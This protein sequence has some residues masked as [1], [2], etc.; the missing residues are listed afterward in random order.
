MTMQQIDTLATIYAQSL[1][2]L[3]EEAGGREK[4]LEL[5]EELEQVSE[6]LAGEA[7]LRTLF[8]TPVIDEETRGGLIRRIFENR[9]TDLL[10]RF[11]LV[12]NANDRLGHFDCIQASYDQMVQDTFGRVEVDVV[13]AI[14]LDEA[15]LARIGERLQKALGKEPILHASIDESIIGGLQLRVGDRLMDGSVATRLRRL[16]EQLRKQGGHAIRTDMER[17]MES[18]T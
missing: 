11:M 3:A 17:F 2:E 7:D 14:E 12:L 5:A 16:G 15:T 13:T 4:I 8:G 10:L 1:L 6:L 9:V 18:S